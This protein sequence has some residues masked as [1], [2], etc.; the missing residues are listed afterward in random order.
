MKSPCRNCKFN[1]RVSDDGDYCYE[2]NKPTPLAITE[3]GG[4]NWKP[5]EKPAIR[6]GNLLKALIA[7][8]KLTHRRGGNFWWWVEVRK[9]QAGYYHS[10]H[11]VMHK[12]HILSLLQPKVGRDELAIYLQTHADHALH[13]A[14]SLREKAKH[15]DDAYAF[16]LMERACNVEVDVAIAQ[17]ILL[18]MRNE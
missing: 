9:V 12:S 16:Q 14:A 10:G 13:Y 11:T 4:S 6:Y 17:E 15:S 5:M 18:R 1:D 2:F 7:T 8:C 3:C